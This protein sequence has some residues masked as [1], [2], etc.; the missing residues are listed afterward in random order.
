MDISIIIVNY[1]GWKALDECLES[2]DTIISKTFSFEVIIVDN[3]SN[4]GQFNIFKQKYSKF[5]FIENTGNNGFSNGCNFGASIATGNHF[6]F[7]NPDT[8]LT[9]EALEILLETAVSHPE[10][11]ILSCLQINE[12]EVFYK[13]NNLFPALGRFFGVSRSIFRKLNKAKLEKRFNNNNELFY[14]D[15]VTGAVIFISR[16]WFNKIQGW[17]E[18]FWL[19]FEDVA[20]CKKI[21][22]TDGKVAVT[23]KATIFHQHGGASRLN[24]K[25]KALTK[26][27]VIISKHVYISNQFSTG[28]QLY[29]HTLLILGVLSEKLF[30][31]LLSVF[32]FF[33]PKLKV[34]RLMLKNLSIY[35]LNVLRKQT[36]ISPRAMNY[37][38]T[39]A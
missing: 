7:L 17:N 24:V 29:L 23:R 8:K 27:E 22:D 16:E 32:L 21:S 13:Q 39:K 6:L 14:P 38:K 26:T 25:T 5:T 18:D 28:I 4:D 36:W 30:L 10:I 12:N 11:G 19:Y 37:L 33:I 15:W 9:L 3:F 34:N 2:I 20:L 35:Y 31:S 1:R